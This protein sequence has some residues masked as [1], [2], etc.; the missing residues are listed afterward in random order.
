MHTDVLRDLIK[1]YYGFNFSNIY[2]GY[3]VTNSYDMAIATAWWTAPVVADKIKATHKVYFIQDFEPFFNPMGDGFIL[4][5]NTYHLGLKPITIGRWL[6]HLMSTTFD[7]S[8]NFFQFTADQDIYKPLENIQREQAVCFV[9]QPEKPRRCPVIGREALSI[10]KYHRPETTIYTYGSAELPSFWFD[11][12][13]LGLLSLTECNQ[14]Y[15]KCTVGLCISSSNPSRIPFEMMSSG[16][17]LVDIYGENTIYDLPEGGVL[18][19]KKTPAAIAGALITI[20]DDKELQEKMRITGTIFMLNRPSDLELKQCATIIE[21]ILT[22]DNK[23]EK[24]IHP[25]YT[26]KPFSTNC[27][28]PVAVES[29]RTNNYSSL[30]Q[31]LHNRL[32]KTMKVLIKGY[33]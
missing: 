14:L 10:V 31:R 12:T 9:Y 2:L 27:P 15:N 11:H 1:Q 13:H 33:Y 20:L 24:E 28:T 26:S 16:L 5:E 29:E 4:A 17:P 6:S 7:T 32:S 8:A 21:N 3:Q 23:S 22:G 18:L 19:S 30:A 25:I